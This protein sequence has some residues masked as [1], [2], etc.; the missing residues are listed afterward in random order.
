[1]MNKQ[2][3]S[4][5]EAM[6][7]MLIFGGGITLAMQVMPAGSAKVTRSRNMTVA[8]NLA[9]EKVED[10]MSLQYGNADLVAGAHADAANPLR[11]HYNRN[12][13]V[14]DDTPISKMK[15]VTVTVSFPTA[16]AD[17]IRTLQT[18]I[19]KRR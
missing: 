12:W 17:S 2:G 15:T 16:S 4:L 11:G 10:L 18:I 13:T 14:V 5:I 6:V 8:M 1:M 9:Q 7:A 3:V 19:S